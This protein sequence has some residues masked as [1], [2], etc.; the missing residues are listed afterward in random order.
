[1]KEATRVMDS[2]GQ[3]LAKRGWI[4]V[5]PVSPDGRS[6]FAEAADQV[7]SVMD[8]MERDPEVRP[9]RILLAGVSNGGIAALQVAGMASDRVS[10][11]IAVPGM[12]HHWTKLWGLKHLPVYLRVG[13]ED[14][15]GWAD[16]YPDMVRRLKNAGTRLDARLLD[17]VGHGVLIDWDELDAWVARELGALGPSP[18]RTARVTLPNSAARIRTW[19]ARDGGTVEAALVEVRGSEVL[20]MQPG[21]TRLRIRRENLSA[22]DHEFLDRLVTSADRGH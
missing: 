8:Q 2:M 19:T 5:V 20:L 22:V 18:K 1:M 16:H 11:V 12:L 13:A 15:L 17:G 21:G 6:F 9:G 7:V 10:G 4:V 14:R 3:D